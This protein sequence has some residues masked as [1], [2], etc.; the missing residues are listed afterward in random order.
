MTS[1]NSTKPLTPAVA[2]RMA[3][4]VADLQAKK[5]RRRAD[6]EQFAHNRAHGLQ[7]RKAAK[8]NRQNNTAGQANFAE[9]RKMVAK[10]KENT[11]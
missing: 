1:G 11:R 7:A 3:A 2:A 4:R 10:D 5:A 6:R 9:V 8:L